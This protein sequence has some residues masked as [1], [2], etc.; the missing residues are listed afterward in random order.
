MLTT[1]MQESEPSVTTGTVEQKDPT[2][3]YR[4]LKI[5]LD[6]WLDRVEHAA[7][8]SSDDALDDVAT[9]LPVVALLDFFRHDFLKL[10]VGKLIMNTEYAAR[11]SAALREARPLDRE[12]LTKYVQA[13]KSMG[14]L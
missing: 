7:A 11:Q 8:A 9:R 5:P 10:G 3:V 1:A 4:T 14:F 6:A 13:W 12:F 2:D